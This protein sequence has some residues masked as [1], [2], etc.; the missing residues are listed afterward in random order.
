MIL[1]FIFM[2]TDLARQQ[3]TSRQQSSCLSFLC[4]TYTT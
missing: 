3:V 1:A 2:Q 4:S